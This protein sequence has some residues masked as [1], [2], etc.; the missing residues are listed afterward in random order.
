MLSMKLLELRDEAIRLGQSEG[1]CLPFSTCRQVGKIQVAAKRVLAD[2]KV[3]I[4]DSLSA[5]QAVAWLP[6]NI[7]ESGGLL[8]TN[9]GD[10][11]AILRRLHGDFVQRCRHAKNSGRA[12]ISTPLDAAISRLNEAVWNVQQKNGVVVLAPGSEFEENLIGVDP[13]EIRMTKPDVSRLEHIRL[14][15]ITGC[16]EVTFHQ[17][18]ILGGCDEVDVIVSLQNG[19]PE[20]RLTTTRPEAQTMYRGRNRLSCEVNVPARRGIPLVVGEFEVSRED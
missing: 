10:P 4:S 6:A 12:L 14:A 18:G 20:V 7:P 2:Y 3:S 9:V 11:A 17:G 19:I 8:S 15:L 13:E 5:T 1:V 16:R